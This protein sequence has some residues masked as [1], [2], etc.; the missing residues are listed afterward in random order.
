MRRRVRM[1]RA[2]F[3]LWRQQRGECPLCGR[4]IKWNAQI[5]DE[6]PTLDHIIPRSLGGCDHID[7]L[8]VA[9]RRCN[10]LR[11]CRLG[12]MPWADTPAVIARAFLAG[13][14]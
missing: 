14:A 3:A 13:A 2:R 10:E 9:H 4:A 6:A 11:G 8:R 12:A 5:E 1:Q 7:N